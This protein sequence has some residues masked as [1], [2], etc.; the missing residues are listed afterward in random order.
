[1]YIESKFWFVLWDSI[2][3]DINSDD[4]SLLGKN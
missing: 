4:S 1:M 2:L 3:I